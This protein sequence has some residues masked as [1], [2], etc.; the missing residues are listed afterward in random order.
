ML[1]LP[2][3]AE[4][5]ASESQVVA[6]MIIKLARF[7]TWPA[8]GLPPSRGAFEVCV[9]GDDRV[10]GH[11]EALA[12]AER[13]GPFPLRVRR[14]TKSR[15]VQGCQ[16]LFIGRS[17]ER[18][19]STVTEPTLTVSMQSGFADEGGIIELS[20]VDGKVS[21]Q[22]NCKAAERVGLQISSRLLALAKRVDR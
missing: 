6:S 1:A 10:F 14:L 16:L 21:F 12:P 22:I 18:H 17:S 9:Y 3:A 7:V 13:V 4:D 15:D 11:L 2:A 8:D 5:I 20:L 19:L